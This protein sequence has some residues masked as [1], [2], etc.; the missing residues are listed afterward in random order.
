MMGLFKWTPTVDANVGDMLREGK[1]AKEIG[2][3]LGVS[4]NSVIGRVSRSKELKAIGF[5]RSPGQ[6]KA[7]SEVEPS[8][9][10]RRRTIRVPVQRKNGPISIVALR[11]VEAP[12]K[13]EQTNRHSEMVAKWLAE[14]G[15]PRRFE[16]GACADYFAVQTFLAQHRVT[17]VA[18]R[19]RYRMSSGNGR[20]RTVGWKEVLVTVDAIR[21]RQ[22][23]QPIMAA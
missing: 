22:G 15:G 9:R 19:G 23:L 16:N 1:T 7:D 12:K 13:S 10:H 18:D 3:A 20:P 11:T 5:S 4:R 2:D 8:I 21:S 14:H 17:V 6:H